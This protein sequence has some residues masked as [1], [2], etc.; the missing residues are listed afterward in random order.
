MS[1]QTI[2]EIDLDVNRPFITVVH[3]KQYDTVRQVKAHL[4]YNGVKWPVPSSDCY[5]VVS[6]KKSDKIGGFY[7]QTEDGR[8]A[9]SVDS[10]DRSIVYLLLDRNV[11]TT[12][13]KSKVE[14]TF[15][16]T[17]GVVNYH[18][19]HGTYFIPDT[20]YY[21]RSGSSEPYTYTRT[22]DTVMQP[23]KTYYTR[24]EAYGRLSTFSFITEVEEATVTELDLSSSPY[25]NIL[26]E[27]IKKVI[28]AADSLTGLTAEGTKLAP[29]ADPT[30]D[31]TGGTSARD[32]YV[33][34]LGIPSMPGM[35]TSATK[36]APNATPTAV[37]SGG[38]EPGEDYNIAFGIPSMPGMT[39]SATQLGWDDDP[40][41]DITGGQTPGQAYNIAFGIPKAVGIVSMTSKYG[42][43]NDESVLPTTWVDTIEELE[44]P[45]GWVGWTKNIALCDDGNTYISYAKALQ[46]FPGPPG[47]AVQTTEP[48]TT[49]K[50]WVNPDQSATPIVIP[51]YTAEEDATIH[52]I[53]G[54]ML[55]T[56][57]TIPNP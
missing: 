22:T 1:L 10:S 6:F 13:G 54:I 50:I 25:F 39:V 18:E 41:A 9:V 44:I 45:D 17:G 23:G 30:A 57:R 7:D 29:D 55:T 42:A 5:A 34:H 21:E 27:D 16:D 51:E 28:E 52:N 32:P 26:A 46:G 49:V 15:Y 43:S 35:H 3:A 33:L 2:T 47:V 56:V 14:L 40:T 11:V 31:I 37:I 24:T 36:L 53:G 19:Y 4:F 20:I 38:T 8:L 48:E 12:A